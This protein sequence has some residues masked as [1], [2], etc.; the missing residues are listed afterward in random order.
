MRG[1]QQQAGSFAEGLEGIVLH[2]GEGGFYEVPWSVVVRY[3]VS[4]GRA[5]ELA[6]PRPADVRGFG[7]ASWTILGGVYEP[8][9]AGEV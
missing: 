5:T 3:R 4:D 2:D 8:E 1:T 6:G 9:P 7:G